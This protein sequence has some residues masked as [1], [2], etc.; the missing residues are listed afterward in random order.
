MKF[1]RPVF[2]NAVLLD[3]V[4]R[5]R[6]HS[7]R[8]QDASSIQRNVIE[9]EQALSHSSTEDKDSES[10][11]KHDDESSP[12]P[13]DL[14][15]STSVVTSTNAVA[16]PY[17]VINLLFQTCVQQA[18]I[19]EELSSNRQVTVCFDEGVLPGVTLSVYETEGR[20][21]GDF[22]CADSLI[23]SRLCE[24]SGSM[25]SELADKLSKD[26]RI[27]V[28]ISTSDDVYPFQVEA[29]PHGDTCRDG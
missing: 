19:S 7:R 20:V 6:E 29:S 11:K 26:T 24:A 22:S 15:I 12:K 13:F 2:P 18:Y 4:H 16:F 1:E 17:E 8:E 25:A 23:W 3:T 14:F 5:T 21:V 10:E 28:R 9:F 27:Y